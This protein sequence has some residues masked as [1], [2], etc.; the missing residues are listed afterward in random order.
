MFRN[1]PKSFCSDFYRT[2]FYIL[3]VAQPIQDLSKVPIAH[4]TLGGC[5]PRLR[6][7]EP[8]TN[9]STALLL[10]APHPTRSCSRRHMG[11]RTHKHHIPPPGCRVSDAFNHISPSGPWLC[12]RYLMAMST[13]FRAAQGPGLD[14][15][16]CLHELLRQIHTPES[17]C[18]HHHTTGTVFDLQF[19]PTVGKMR[20]QSPW[21]GPCSFLRHGTHLPTLRRAIWRLGISGQE[22]RVRRGHA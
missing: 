1:D 9:N 8:V 2:R 13:T 4:E 17:K 5:L 20:P 3:M 16:M 11:G 6:R 12:F 21:H 22:R 7:S 15:G 19:S 14:A 18:L 10:T